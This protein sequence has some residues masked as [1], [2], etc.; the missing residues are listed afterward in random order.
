MAERKPG[1]FLRLLGTEG[2]AAAEA[3]SRA[4]LVT[5]PNC[6]FSRSVWDLGGVR[7]KAAGTARR[8]MRCPQCGQTGWHLVHKGPDFPETTGPSW[9]LVRLILA[10]VLLILLAVAGVLL[11][12]FKLTGLI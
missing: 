2:A 5:C 9:P 7:Y 12:V 11:L 10:L 4:W 1:L 3:E 8:A 6:G